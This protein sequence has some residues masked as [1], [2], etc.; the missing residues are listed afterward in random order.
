MF[1]GVFIVNDQCNSTN[2]KLLSVL[3]YVGPLFLTARFSVEYKEPHVKFHVKQ[4]GILFCFVVLCYLLTFFLSM[5]LSA[6]PAVEEIVS[7]LLL[8]GT[9]VAWVILTV[10]GI[11]GALKGQQRLLPIIGTIDKRIK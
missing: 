1:E 2:I 8:V 4:G 10:M 9:T 3:F 5:A 11:S 7:L 6:L